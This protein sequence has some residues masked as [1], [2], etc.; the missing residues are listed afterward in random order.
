MLTVSPASVATEMSLSNSQVALCAVSWSRCNRRLDA[1]S[2]GLARKRTCRCTFFGL[3][4]LAGRWEKAAWVK[5][6]RG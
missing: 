4:R 1:H 5:F 2:D 6:E 3:G